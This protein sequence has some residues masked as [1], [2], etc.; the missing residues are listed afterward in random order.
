MPLDPVSCKNYYILRT[1]RLQS[2]LYGTT[3]QQSRELFLFT[4]KQEA[5]SLLLTAREMPGV[6]VFCKLSANGRTCGWMN[7]TSCLQLQTGCVRSLQRGNIHS[8]STKRHAEV[9]TCLKISYSRSQFG[10][11]PKAA[12]CQPSIN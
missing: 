2:L 11:F 8:L 6:G 12:S 5:S 10:G 1:P 3:T 7:N 9:R 4:F